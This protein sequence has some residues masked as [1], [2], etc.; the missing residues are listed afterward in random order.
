MLGPWATLAFERLVLVD[1]Q[2]GDQQVQQQ[3]QSLFGA[4]IMAPVSPAA[5][6]GA[7]VTLREVA[8]VLG[9]CPPASLLLPYLAMV[10]APA[11]GTQAGMFDLRTA[12]PGCV[13]ATR[14]PDGSVVPPCQRCWGYT[15]K[16]LDGAAVTP[17]AGDEAEG[18]WDAGYTFRLNNMTALCQYVAGRDQVMLPS[19]VSGRGW[20]WFE[21]F[22]RDVDSARAATSAEVQR[23]TSTGDTSTPPAGPCNSSTSSCDGMVAGSASIPV[24]IVAGVAA[25][26]AIACCALAL[27]AGLWLRRRKA[28]RARAAQGSSAAGP[29]SFLSSM[30]KPSYLLAFAQGAKRKAEKRSTTDLHVTQSSSFLLATGGSSPFLRANTGPATAEDDP[31][32]ALGGAAAL[33]PSALTATDTPMAERHGGGCRGEEGDEEGGLQEVVVEQPTSPHTWQAPTHVV[34]LMPGEDS[35]PDNATSG[36]R[37][38]GPAPGDPSSEC[39]P[40]HGTAHLSRQLT[41]QL[42]PLVLGHG[43][44]G[45][46]YAGEADGQAVAVKLLPESLGDLSSAAAVQQELEVLARCTHPCVVRVLAACTKP[47]RPCIVMER[48]ETSLDGLLYGRP[49]TLLPLPVVVHIALEVAR[50]LE[51]LHPTVLHG[52]LKPGNVLISNPDSA[53]PDVKITDAGLSQAR[54][55]AT[56]Q[57]GHPD[58]GTAA[59]LAPESF[60]PVDEVVTCKTDIYS[61]GVLVWEALAGVQPWLGLTSANIALYVHE[62]D[63][64]L[65]MPPHGTR[66]EDSSR[67]PGM[68][69]RLLT[70]CW[71]KDPLRRPAAAE[72]VRRLLVIQQ[73]L[74]HS[75]SSSAAAPGSGRPPSSSAPADQTP[76]GELAQAMPSAS[77]QQ[78]DMGTEWDPRAGPAMRTP[79]GDGGHSS[80]ITASLGTGSGLGSG[81]GSGWGSGLGS[82]SG[83]QYL[84]SDVIPKLGPTDA[85]PNASEAWAQPGPTT[86]GGGGG[87]AGQGLQA[88]AAVERASRRQMGGLLG[89]SVPHALL[90]S[91]A[92]GTPWASPI[93]EED[94]LDL[95]EGESELDI[96][97]AP[98]SDTQ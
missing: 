67:W 98:R 34:I 37:P 42:Q 29:S 74:R 22:T 81:V 43:V 39:R 44:L 15:L 77:D 62:Y 91:T 59:Y 80:R 11:D 61:W 26:G 66:G 75:L 71:D 30:S 73:A 53:T 65:P 49:D 69:V 33:G 56:L 20:E 64:R 5:T 31:A 35:E 95:W 96:E 36:G 18:L 51:Y 58:P 47:P 52:D 84:D 27:V 7:H 93:P 17:V 40:E 83:D 38:A 12:Q 6:P 55:E 90:C 10:A 24:G 48:M 97:M 94:E 4:E 16:V 13:N 2:A 89:R 50:G 46:V 88:P 57:T 32:S 72:L 82:G 92:R 68:M 21:E 28:A 9:V 8:L 79:S 25:G 85:G 3:Q 1:M 14:W 70:E 63:A 60:K 45:R 19:E 76:S 41:V 86:T 23:P 87:P 78:R 54:R